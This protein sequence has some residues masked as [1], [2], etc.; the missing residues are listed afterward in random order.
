MKI[1][2][3]GEVL[4]DCPPCWVNF[5]HQNSEP[6]PKGV[7]IPEDVLKQKLKQ[8]GGSFQSSHSNNHSHYWLEFE[9]EEGWTMFSL[10]WS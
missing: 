4:R 8:F 10:Q 2:D 6:F 7:N 3:L 1:V 9:T 5:I